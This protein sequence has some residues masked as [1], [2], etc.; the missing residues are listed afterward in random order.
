MGEGHTPEQQIQILNELCQLSEFKGK[1]SVSDL[2]YQIISRYGHILVNPTDNTID[3]SLIEQ[4]SHWLDA[5]P[6]SLHLYEAALM[7][8]ENRLFLRNLL[9]DIRLSL[10]KLTK[11]LLKNNKSL[12]NQIA[13]IGTFLK[14]SGCSKELINMFQKLIDYYTKYHNTYIKHDDAVIESEIEI[15]FEITCSFMRFL[16]R[17]NTI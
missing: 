7:K 5:F 16:I 17:A 11:T 10:E 2:R 9:D 4:T 6:D 12:E 8:F 14:D 3:R 1:T 13:D 15:I